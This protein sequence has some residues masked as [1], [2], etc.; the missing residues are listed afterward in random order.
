MRA[1]ARGGLGTDLLLGMVAAAVV[2]VHGVGRR[3]PCPSGLRLELVAPAVVAVAAVKSC[4]PAL[5]PA[6]RDSAEMTCPWALS[7]LGG[8]GSVGGGWSPVAALGLDCQRSDESAA[9]TCRPHSKTR[10]EHAP[11]LVLG[12]CPGSAGARVAAAGVSAW[13]AAAAWLPA[14]AATCCSNS[15]APDA[16]AAAVD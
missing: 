9:G 2:A 7:R 4:T 15:A 14:L 10:R 11:G 1:R 13:S 8:F 5:P 6:Q 12:A 3:D 16:A